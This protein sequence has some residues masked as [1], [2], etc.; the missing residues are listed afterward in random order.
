M[1]LESNEEVRPA[2]A[3]LTE[4]EARSSTQAAAARPHNRRRVAVRVLAAT[5]LT[6]GLGLNLLN[7]LAHSRAV[8]AK[9]P[10]AGGGGRPNRLAAPHT[11]NW[12]QLTFTTIVTG[13]ASPVGI[14]HAGDASNR[15][16]IVEQGG[17]IRIVRNGGLLATNFL[18]ITDRISSGSERGLLGLAFPP[19]FATKQ[20]FYVNYTNQ[21]GDTRVSRFSVSQAN[22][23]VADP[24]SEHI[25]LTVTQPFANHNGGELQFG[26]TDG[27]LY[28]GLGDGGSGG[29]PNNNG[30][31]PAALLG[32]MLRIDTESV[33]NTYSIP[34]TNPFTQTGGYAGEIWQLGLRNPW[35]YTFDRQT[36]DL[37]IADVGQDSWEEVDVQ[38]ASSSGGENWGWRLMEG[39]HC[40]N[41]PTNCNVSNTLALPVFEYDHSLGCSI[42]G[43]YV[44]R[45]PG[46]ERMQGI[47]FA[48]DECSGRIWGLHQVNS[49]WESTVL[50]DTT[51]I[52]TTFGEDEPGNLYFTHYATSAGVLYK[53]G[54]IVTPTPTATPTPTRTPTAT[55]TRTPTPTPTRTPTATPTATP[56]PARG[57]CNADQVVDA[58]DLSAIALELFDGDGT[59]PA[60]TY[61]GTYAG[62]PTGCNA[63]GDG[64]VDGADISC[65]VRLIFLGQGTCG[66]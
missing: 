33:T 23:D 35:R 34:P 28:I 31:N 2:D 45:G 29:D 65:A 9:V 57:N 22:S 48:G 53:V 18:S 51:N 24:A 58:G 66:P 7:A 12:P 13:L 55:A 30:Q 43:G 59:N 32:K 15:L 36:H 10:A 42:I 21:S 39:N 25:L 50:T 37:Y 47:Y 63:N 62:D 60:A 41:P 64:A 1:L 40:Y 56:V 38:P 5:A 44:Y 52:I 49:I 46:F 8:E 11:T 14:V 20:Y 54:D 27:Y 4:A 16:F 19:G 26:P 6:L 61:G 3:I 17:R